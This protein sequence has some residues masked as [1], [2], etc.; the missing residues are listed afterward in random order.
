YNSITN[1]DCSTGAGIMFSCN[2]S[3]DFGLGSANSNNWQAG[4]VPA[5]DQECF[6]GAGLNVIR[7]SYDYLTTTM[8]ES[9]ITPID[10]TTVCGA[11]GLSNCT[12]SPGIAKGVYL[13]EGDVNLNAFTFPVDAL[14]P[15]SFV[16]LIHGDLRIQGNILVPAGSVAAFSTSGNIYVD[17][18]V[19]NLVTNTSDAANNNPN[20]EGLYSADA[21]FIVES[22]GSGTNLCNAD[23]TPF[24]KRLVVVGSIITNAAKAGG[25]Y[26]NNRDLC[27]YD[28]E[29]P[30]V[31]F[32]DGLSVDSGLGLSYLLTLYADGKF[33]SHKVFNW[34]ELRP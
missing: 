12:L 9:G 11:G 27:L 25:S 6:S 8:R 1:A 20:V 2:G 30:S 32:G 31:S 26:Q 24:D 22:Y 4:G 13:A 34:Q 18:S 15:Q 7:T 23:G 17:K 19:G 3:P 29:C 10:M 33:L 21:N 16:F 28:L 14:H 5:A